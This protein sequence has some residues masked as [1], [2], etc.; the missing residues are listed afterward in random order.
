MAQVVGFLLPINMGRPGSLL[1]SQVQPGPALAAV[2][3]CVMNKQKEVSHSYSFIVSLK[4]K[5]ML[6]YFICETDRTSV[7]SLSL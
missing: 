4:G 6:L 1:C 3:I 5:E 2:Y 7:C